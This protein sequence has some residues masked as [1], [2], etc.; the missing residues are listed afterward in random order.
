MTSCD[1]ARGLIE[2]V[3]E[4][5]ISD[6]QFAELK[7]HTQTCVTCREELRRCSL[8]EEVVQDAFATSTAAEQA[9]RQVLARLETMPRPEARVVRVSWMRAVAACL[10]LGAGLLLGFAAGKAHLGGPPQTPS[11][12]RVP[13]RVGDLQGMVLVRHDNSEVWQPLATGAEVYLGDTFHSSAKADLVLE[14]EDGKST[15][16]LGQN[17]MLA[18]TSYDGETQFFLEHG[19]CT[20]SLEGPH[21]PFFIRT[22]HGRVEALGTEFTVAVE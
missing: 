15:I 3:V 12:V 2:K 16:Q 22:P 6:V 1:H 13:I 7:A 8:V 5:T 21:G 9:A 17:S 14:L 18:L 19:E 10:I 4:G 20:A 11:L